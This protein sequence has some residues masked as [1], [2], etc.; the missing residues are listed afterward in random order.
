MVLDLHISHFL[1]AELG[2]FSHF[3]IVAFILA[4]VE[5]AFFQPKIN[6]VWQLLRF[7]YRSSFI[8]LT[9]SQHFQVI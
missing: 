6:L 9:L 2:H 7:A 3:F 5:K 1:T 8:Y 4:P